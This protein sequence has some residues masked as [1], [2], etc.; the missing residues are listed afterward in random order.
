MVIISMSPG[1]VLF[2]CLSQK[3]T[4]SNI[5]FSFF[6]IYL[7]VLGL[8]GGIQGPGSSTRMELGPPDQEH[9]HWTTMEIP[10]NPV[11][12]DSL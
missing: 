8:S 12:D 7:A 4:F 10:E 9:R 2:C 5:C 1:I 3:T 6:I 11:F